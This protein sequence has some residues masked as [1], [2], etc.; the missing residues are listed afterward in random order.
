[1]KRI[2][3][4]SMEEMCVEYSLTPEVIQK[5]ISEEWIT[6]YD[7][8]LLIFDDE[9]L[10]RVGLICELKNNLG[11]NDEAMTIILHL[12]DQ[13]NLIKRMRTNI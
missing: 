5:F 13:L 4:L 1:M 9:D 10:A 3:Q 6:P 12:V 8:D 11:V 7:M 2:I